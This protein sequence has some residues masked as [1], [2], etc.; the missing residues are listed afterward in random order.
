VTAVVVILAV[1]VVLATLRSGPPH[2][3][4]GEQLRRDEEDIAIYGAVVRPRLDEDER[5]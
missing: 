1:F 4:D 2:V 5:R 3:P